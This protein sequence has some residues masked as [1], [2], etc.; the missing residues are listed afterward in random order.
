MRERVDIAYRYD[1]SFEGLLCCVYD[2]YARREL[3]CAIAA[4]GAA[5]SSLFEERR[6][7]TDME[8]AERVARGIRERISPEALEFVKLSHLT[9]LDE[10]E[11]RILDFIRLG[12]CVGATVLDML[13][14]PS[15]SAL[16]QAVRRLTHEAHLLKGFIRFSD[17]RGAL[18]ATITPKNRVL[19]LLA[20]HFA[21]RYSGER[22]LIYDR[23]HATALACEGGRTA[24][25]PMENLQ[26]NAPD[27][28]ELLFRALWRRFYETIGIEGRRNERCRMSHMPKRYWANMTEFQQDEPAT[29]AIEMDFRLR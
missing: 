4:D 23:T 6:V 20:D 26:L 16:M 7:R 15:V 18:V 19:P 11:V 21:D 29:A 24:L 9:C 1:G 17:Q 28:R 12:F 3:P 27:E 10:R 8:R 13:A 2:S 25:V 22:V 5:Q 14:D